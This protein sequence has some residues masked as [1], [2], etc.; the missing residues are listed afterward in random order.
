[1]SKGILLPQSPV[2]RDYDSEGLNLLYSHN[3]FGLSGHC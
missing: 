2:C 3:T 1:M